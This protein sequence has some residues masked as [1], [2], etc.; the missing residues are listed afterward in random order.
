MVKVAVLM[1]RACRRASRA[2]RIYT[3]DACLCVAILRASSWLG[4][5]LSRAGTRTMAQSSVLI[6]FMR[7]MFGLLA[8]KVRFNSYM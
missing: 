1:P 8:S 5:A 7:V 3:L 6:N 4:C 2:L